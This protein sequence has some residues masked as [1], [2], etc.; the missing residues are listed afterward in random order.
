MSELLRVSGLRFN[1]SVPETKKVE[2]EFRR[3]GVSA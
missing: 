2:R 3:T 1:G